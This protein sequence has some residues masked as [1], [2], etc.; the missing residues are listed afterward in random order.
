MTS[1]KYIIWGSSGHSKVIA[2]IILSNGSE[3]IALFDSDPSAVSSLRGIPLYHGAQGFDEWKNSTNYPMKEVVGALAIGGDKGNDR[4]ELFSKLIKAG[5]ACPTIMHPTAVISSSAS[6]GD[7][8][9]VL[10]SAIVNADVKIGN[11]CILNTAAKVDHECVIGNGV[12]IAPGATLCGCV[13]VMDN[14][15]IGAGAVILPRITVGRGAIV[16]AGAVVTKDVADGDVVAG[17]PA[18]VM[19]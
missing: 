15:F 6:F 11:V 1:Q 18:R 3:V 2:E 13:T 7:G 10:V 5:I 17:V 9:Q 16:G 8:S 4:Q 14:A 12:H 19:V